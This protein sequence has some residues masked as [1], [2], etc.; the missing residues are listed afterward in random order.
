MKPSLDRRR[1]PALAAAGAALFALP[2]C[3]QQTAD[4]A[5]PPAAAA[6]RPPNVVVI[7]CDDLGYTDVGC[8]GAQGWTTPNLDRMAREGMR[9]TSFYAAQAVCSASRAGLLTGCYPNRVG[10]TGALTPNSAIGLNPAET[11]IASMLKARG[12][13]TGMVGKWHLG[14]APRFMPWNHGFDDYFGLPYSNDMWPWRHG[15]N[16]K[17]DSRYPA[18]AL[19]DGPKKAGE[20]LTPADQDQ[21]T[22]RYTEHATA[23]IRAHA[24]EPFFLY[25]AHSM[26]H[27]P[28]GVSDKFRGKSEQGKYGDVVM[29]LDWSVGEVLRTLK[30]CGVDGNTL[31][32]F[33]SDNGP[34]LNYGN[35]AGTCR[36]LREGKGTSFEGGQREPCIMRWPGRIPAGSECRQL[37][38]TI[39]LLPTFAALAGAKLPERRIDGV[40]MSPL[41]FGK[42]GARPRTTLLYYYNANDLEAVRRDQWKLVLPHAHRSYAGCTPGRDGLP[43]PTKTAKTGLALYDLTND[44]GETA[45]VKDTHPGIVAELQKLAAEA[46]ADLGDNLEKQPG[47]GRR[48]P[49][50]RETKAAAAPTNK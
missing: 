25:F 39:D 45:D 18:L 44:P 12:Y 19:Y 7:L 48:A 5:T 34:W 41:L 10:I 31:V 21:L 50:K 4:S 49:G 28:L 30:E 2:A 22:T 37:A 43:G 9:F 17:P 26:P 11:T 24:K 15:E 29:E 14:D 3:A 36:G 47:S 35:H 46:R 40:D 38:C 27:V 8:F 6:A 20:I 32:V 1:L 13:A 42:P 16:P 23:F 33:T